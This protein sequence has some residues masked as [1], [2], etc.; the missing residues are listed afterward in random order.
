[1]HEN[2][3]TA[4]ELEKAGIQTI[5]QFNLYCH[6]GKVKP[7]GCHLDLI[8]ALVGGKKEETPNH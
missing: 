6:S 8:F 2:E 4:G 3:L 1:M 5:T 7:S